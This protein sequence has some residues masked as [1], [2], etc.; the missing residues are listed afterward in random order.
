SFDAVLSR[1]NADHGIDA[2]MLQRAKQP[3]LQWLD[4]LPEKNVFW[5]DVAS[6]TQTYPHRYRRWQEV[7]HAINQVSTNDLR[8][9]ANQ[10][11]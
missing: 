2:D 8:H 3:L 11:L 7:R 1:V 4:S 10:Y 6:L 5:L 9:V